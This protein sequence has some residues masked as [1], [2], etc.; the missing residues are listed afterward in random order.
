[1]TGEEL[2]DL[3]NEATTSVGIAGQPSWSTMS[4]RARMAMSSA[5]AKLELAGTVQ[6]NQYPGFQ[7]AIAQQMAAANQATMQSLGLSNAQLAQAQ[8]RQQFVRAPKPPH[9]VALCRSCKD[10][11]VHASHDPGGLCWDCNE[12]RR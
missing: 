10:P 7:Q 3:L 1:M 6:P 2:M 5:A 8:S 9:G 4:T 12:A 11:S